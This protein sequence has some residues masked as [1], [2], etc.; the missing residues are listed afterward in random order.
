MGLSCQGIAVVV[1][2]CVDLA[3][4]ELHFPEFPSYMLSIGP[5]KKCT[6]GLAAMHLFVHCVGQDRARQALKK[7]RY[8]VDDLVVHLAC[9]EQ[10][11][12]QQFPGSLGIS[13]FSF[14]AFWAKYT[15][16]GKGKRIS[17]SCIPPTSPWL[18]V[19]GER[20]GHWFVSGHSC[21]SSWILAFPYFLPPI[22]IYISFPISSPDFRKTPGGETTA[23]HYCLSSSKG[24][25][26]SH[27]Y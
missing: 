13:S 24:C 17:L 26:K 22:Y 4:L 8:I 27:S 1:S 15:P 11:L 2:Y 5:Q 12:F 18:K 6:Q 20:E 9:V 21:L 19:M 25:I 10:W 16:G 23:L 3:Q 7:L 14:S